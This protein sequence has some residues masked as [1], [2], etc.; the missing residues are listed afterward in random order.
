MK[1]EVIP[2]YSKSLKL[3]LKSS[4]SSMNIVTA[5]NTWVVTV[6][7]YCVNVLKWTQMEIEQLDHTI[8]KTMAMHG[9]LHAKATVHRLYMKKCK[10][11]RGVI[12]VWECNNSKKETK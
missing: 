12:S 3:L 1:D 5:I 2:A 9:D 6:V 7:R 8:Q 4:L 11:G 10:G